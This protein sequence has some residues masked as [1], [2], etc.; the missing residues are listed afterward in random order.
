[1][2]S[3]HCSQPKEEGKGPAKRRTKRVLAN[4]PLLL[5][6]R[7][8]DKTG[9]GYIRWVL[10]FKLLR[11]LKHDWALPRGC[12]PARPSGCWPLM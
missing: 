6:F 12:W 3:S 11:Q 2:P 8:I 10:G 7:Y 9:A 1:M 4:A 5:A